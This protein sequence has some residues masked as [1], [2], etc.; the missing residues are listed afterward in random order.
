M[1]VTGLRNFVMAIRKLVLTLV[2]LEVVSWARAE[3]NANRHILT[4][5][6]CFSKSCLSFHM[7]LTN[8]R[9]DFF[10]RCHMV[11][12]ASLWCE[13]FLIVHL[14]WK[15]LKRN[16]WFMPQDSRTYFYRLDD[17]SFS[18]WTSLSTSENINGWRLC[19]LFKYLIIK[20]Y[21]SEQ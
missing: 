19:W 2:S 1:G 6:S 20:K 9:F 13:P 3:K 21:I 4:C 16:R 5:W 7:H 11:N 10:P 15:V 18:I 17:I 8:Q 12:V 14:L